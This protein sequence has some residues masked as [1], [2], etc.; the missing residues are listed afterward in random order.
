MSTSTTLEKPAITAS[1]HVIVPDVKFRPDFNK[2]SFTF[3]HNL[4]GHPLLTLPKL[5]ELAEYLLKKEGPGTL[6]WKDSTTPVDARWEQLPPAQ[7]MKS[8]TE[9]IANLDKSGSWVVLYR[10]QNHPEYNAIL[11]QALDDIEE[12]IGRPLRPEITWA[13]SYI[14]MASPQALTPYHID[15]ETAFLMQVHGDRK[16]YLWDQT[17]RSVLSEQELEDYYM[18][19]L[20]AGSYRQENLPKAHVHAMDAGKG[21]HHPVLAPHY[22]QNGDDYSIAIGVHLCLRDVDQMGR[23]YQAN[24]FLRKLGMKPTPVGVDPAKDKK[25]IAFMNLF[26]K[27]NP[28]TKFDLIR[29]GAWRLRKPVNLLSKLAGKKPAPAKSSGA[30]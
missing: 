29:S 25:K 7:Q 14:F 12:M 6:R 8:V 13:D 21:V 27:K 3:D 18:G 11:Q 15:H 22:Y 9:A 24:S 28:T 1:K 17:D 2:K 19:N 23:A 30:M 16:A 20:G 4:K 10:V 5:T 26:D